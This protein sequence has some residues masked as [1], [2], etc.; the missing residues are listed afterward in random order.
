MKSAGRDLIQGLI[1]GV[2]AMGGALAS[3][4]GTLAR[5]AIDALK[6]ALGIGSPS[7]VGLALGANVGASIGIGMV[8]GLEGASG[9][10]ASA[11]SGLT[12]S[13]IGGGRVT[14]PAMVGGG[15]TV[16]NTYN[17][18]AQYRNYQNEGSLRDTV[19]LLQAGVG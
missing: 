11:L 8:G 6:R 5:Q 9:M 18:T 12:A 14:A 4:A 10:I 2:G 16:N 15:T 7:K 17:L 13:A 3:A 19:R 1:D